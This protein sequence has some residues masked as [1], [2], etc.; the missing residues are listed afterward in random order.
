M[1]YENVRGVYN[2]APN[3]FDRGVRENWAEVFC[4]SCLPSQ[5]ST[6]VRVRMVPVLT[7]GV[8]MIRL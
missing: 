5:A 8:D 2:D 4:F 7:V 6:R 1:T 3:P